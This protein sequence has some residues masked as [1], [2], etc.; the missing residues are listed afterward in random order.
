MAALF[1]QGNVLF[2]QGPLDDAGLLIA[3]VHLALQP[4]VDGLGRVQAST[5]KHEWPRASD[6]SMAD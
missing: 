3:A 6:F 2:G 5:C 4:S 1:G